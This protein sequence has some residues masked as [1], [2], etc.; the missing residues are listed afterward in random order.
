MN[1]QLNTSN[2]ERLHIG[3]FGRCN[4]GKSSLIN[5]LTGQAV[6]IVSDIAG[7]TTDP[8]SKPMEFPD[9][10]AVVLIDTAG[11]DDT[12]LLGKKRSEQTMK[13]LDKTDIAVLLFGNQDVST[14][15]EW[16]SE[17]QK[18]NI[19]VIGVIPKCDIAS[20][21]LSLGNHIYTQTR[22]KPIILSAETGDGIN[23]LR[24]AIANSIESDKILLT[25]GLCNDG[26][27]VI[28]VMPQDSQAPKGRLIKPQVQVLRELLDRGCNALCCT[29]AGLHSALASLTSPPQLIIT[30]SQV[31][32]TV[33][34]LKPKES[35]LTSFSILF[36][37]Y[38]G[39]IQQFV[40][41][42]KYIDRLSPTSRILIAEACTHTPQHEDIG[43]VKLPNM[44]RRRIG[45]GLQI[46]IVAGNDFP[47]DLSPYDLIIHCGACMFNRRH[48]MNRIAKAN[49][50]HVPITNYGVAIAL[51]TG[52]LSKVVYEKK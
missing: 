42:A 21:T 5:A 48:V 6:A 18:R 1:P 39:D 43:R 41:G 10:G 52:I 17:M 34:P 4:S 8:V 23:L 3:F 45:E 40:D 2:A 15:K 27:N 30:D 13:V 9:L 51:L 31:F 33:Y 44:L 19:P 22:L 49:N 7:T 38:K 25:E 12:T 36:A 37:R 14:E 20:D 47:N 50:Q 32:G 24:K 11:F 28:L 46:D 26:D 35:L 16:C 29:D